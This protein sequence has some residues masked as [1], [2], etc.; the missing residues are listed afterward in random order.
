M[1]RVVQSEWAIGGAPELSASRF[2]ACPF[3]CPVR[4]CTAPGIWWPGAPTGSWIM[5]AASMS[6]SKIRGYRI[7]LGEIQAALAG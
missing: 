4:G 5:W 1:S 3:G 2:V 7:E 6:R